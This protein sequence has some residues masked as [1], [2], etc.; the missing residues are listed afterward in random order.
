MFRRVL[1]VSV[2]VYAAAAV[3]MSLPSAAARENAIIPYGFVLEKAKRV[4][5]A[6][7]CGDMCRAYGQRPAGK[8]P[9]DADL[10]RTCEAWSFDADGAC[11][12]L[13][14]TGV[15][16]IGTFGDKDH[17]KGWKRHS[18]FRGDCTALAVSTD[19]QE[20]KKVPTAAAGSEQYMR[21]ATCCRACSQDADCDVWEQGTAWADGSDATTC[22]FKRIFKKSAGGSSSGVIGVG[23]Y[24]VDARARKPKPYYG[25]RRGM[26]CKDVDSQRRMSCGPPG[27]ADADTCQAYGCCW[28]ETQK[29]CFKSHW[30]PVA[31]MH[32]MGS[33]LMEYNKNVNWLRKAFPGIYVRQLNIFPGPPSL[34]N[35]MAPQMEA[36][37]LAIAS[38]PMFKD[39]F[40]FY[41]ESQ[42]GLIARVYVS[43]HNDPPVHNLIAISGP[44]SGVGAC[45][46]LNIPV[47]GP[48]CAGGAG[49]LDIYDWPHCSFCSFWRGTNRKKYLKRNK[50]LKIVNNQH[51]AT[52]DMNRARRMMTLNKYMASAGSDDKVVQPRESAWH[53][54]W[55]W[56]GRKNVVPFNETAGFKNDWLGLRTLYNQGKYVMNMY[57]G[58]H[59]SYQKEWWIEEVLPMFD[60][61]LDDMMN[62]DNL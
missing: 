11:T 8:L 43:E 56:G 37:K 20:Y 40:N 21:D 39:G 38:D 36:V 7:A 13:Q 54:F 61:S 12:L 44:Q 25:E 10:T 19:G 45:P 51:D 27:N 15:K 53:T 57:E 22:T 35:P 23:D 58:T 24:D 28:D 17:G 14:L 32:G 5:D 6:S 29:A 18:N 60:N 55:H 41:G 30:T 3:L 49:V 48:I 52:R 42:G 46:E 50:W 62:R 33:R 16:H 59:T 31:V 2:A 34:T 1:P 47:I 4:R 9:A 26:V